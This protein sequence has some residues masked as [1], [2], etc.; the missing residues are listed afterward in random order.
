MAMNISSGVDYS[1]LF[2]TNASGSTSADYSGVLNLDL[3]DV[4]SVRNGSYGKLMK[5]YYKQE[6]AEAKAAKQESDDSLSKIRSSSDQLGIAAEKVQSSKLWESDSD[7]KLKNADDAVK[8]VKDFAS[9]YNDTLKAAG[10]SKTKSVLRNA[11]WMDTMTQK[12]ANL[13]SK[14][15]ITV[16]DDG[17]ISVDEEKL[18]SA[19][20]TTLKEIFTGNDSFAAKVSDKATSIGNAATKTEGLY[21]GKA[22]WSSEMN[23]LAKSSINKV[24]GDDAKISGETKVTG[25]TSKTE[26]TASTNTGKTELEDKLK[27]LNE[28]MDA[29]KKSQETA[30]DYTTFKDYDEQIKLLNKE[31]AET[32]TQ[33]GGN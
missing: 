31:I 6:K 14:A 33:L 32:Q 21:T 4:A 2:G 26:D 11:G 28:R 24:V 22:S 27:D 15:G 5:N 13:L 9:A 1:V 18:K 19:D 29:L 8:A 16:K 25:A 10:D 12:N 30:T 17:T 3:A 7:G 23:D 20:A